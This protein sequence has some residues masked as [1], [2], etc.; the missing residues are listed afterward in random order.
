MEIGVLALVFSGFCGLLLLVLAPYQR[1]VVRQEVDY[2]KLYAKIA[3]KELE[4]G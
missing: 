4:W 2:Q 1:E 3:V